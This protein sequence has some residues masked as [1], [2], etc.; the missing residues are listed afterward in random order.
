M[1]YFYFWKS[2]FYSNLK[3]LYSLFN[4]LLN[5]SIVILFIFSLNNSL[6]NLKKSNLLIYP[7]SI[8]LL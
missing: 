6:L 7:I 4:G 1:S 2:S 8:F 5:Y 3:D